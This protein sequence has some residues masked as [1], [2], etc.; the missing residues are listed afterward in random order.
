MSTSLDERLLTELYASM[1][2]QLHL[3]SSHHA[4]FLTT[5]IGSALRMRCTKNQKNE[6]YEMLVCVANQTEYTPR[7]MNESFN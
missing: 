4:E 5:A 1:G 3:R 7:S 6:L 2:E